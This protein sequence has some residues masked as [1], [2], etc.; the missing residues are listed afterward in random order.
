MLLCFYFGSKLLPDVQGWDSLTG[1]TQ[2]LL[3]VC[4]SQS[5]PEVGPCLFTWKCGHSL[6]SNTASAPVQFRAMYPPALLLILTKWSKDVGVKAIKNTGCFTHT[7]T[8]AYKKTAFYCVYSS[9]TKRTERLLCDSWLN[10]QINSHAC[11]LL[12]QSTLT[13]YVCFCKKF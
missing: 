4:F 8:F 1:Q 9:I 12:S 13:W 7:V 6:G 2:R 3:C 10:C 11:Y 5:L